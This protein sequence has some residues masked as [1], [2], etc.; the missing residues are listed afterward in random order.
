MLLPV[1]LTPD[2]TVHDTTVTVN[3]VGIRRRLSIHVEADGAEVQLRVD[4][5]SGFNREVVVLAHELHLESRGV[6]FGR[7]CIRLD[8]GHRLSSALSQQ[9][10]ANLRYSCY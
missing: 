10:R 5:F 2:E 3:A 9:A 1:L 7:G 4:E 8:P 6:V